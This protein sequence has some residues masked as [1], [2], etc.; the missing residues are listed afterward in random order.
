MVV[1]DICKKP[2]KNST[3]T[4][5]TYIPSEYL[6]NS[7]TVHSINI[8]LSFDICPICI[9]KILKENGMSQL[10]YELEENENANG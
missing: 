4:I 8:H 2:T 10:F 1:C 5:D 3:V 7:K 9:N 6:N